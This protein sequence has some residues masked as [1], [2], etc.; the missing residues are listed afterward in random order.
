MEKNKKFDA[1]TGLRCVAAC[2]V[3]FYHNRKYWRGFL[4]SFMINFLNEFYLG[5]S[6][7]FVLSGF[8]IAHNYN[9][10]NINTIGQYFPYLINRIGR[11]YP[12]Y[13][14]VLTA[15][16][17]DKGYGN[18][19]FNFLN[20]SLLHGFSERHNLDAIAQAWSLTVEMTFYLLAP[21][22][23]FL[24]NKKWIYLLCFLIFFFL[25]SWGIGYALQFSMLKKYS[26]LYPFDFLFTSTFGGQ[27]I[28]FLCGMLLSK[29][30]CSNNILNKFEYNLIN[31]T[32]I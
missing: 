12:V 2:M 24:M 5:V 22:L 28:L 3:F 11:I 1:L 21:L 32:Q 8:L 17:L 7:F 14:L 25:C 4:P 26:F 31:E 15:Y 13:W 23:L 10:R 16:Y 18:F 27:S 19:H 9:K 20:Y 29:Y 30:M 6:V